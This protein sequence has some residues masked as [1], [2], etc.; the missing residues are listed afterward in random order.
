MS[1]VLSQAKPF[2]LTKKEQDLVNRFAYYCQE[3]ADSKL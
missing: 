2:K 1:V 3:L